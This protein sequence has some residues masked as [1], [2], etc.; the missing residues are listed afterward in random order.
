MAL[1]CKASKYKLRADLL[2]GS[3]LR[4]STGTFYV[5]SPPSLSPHNGE[6]FPLTPT[7]FFD[8]VFYDIW[9][10]QSPLLGF[11]NVR[12]ESLTNSETRTIVDITS[13]QIPE[14]N[15]VFTSY[16][17][18]TPVRGI[19]D[20]WSLRGAGKTADL[21]GTLELVAYGTDAAGYPFYVIY[22]TGPTF[23]LV[24]ASKNKN[25][26]DEG[27]FG[28]VLRAL[29]ETGPDIQDLVVSGLPI[30]SNGERDGLPETSCGFSCQNNLI[31]PVGECPPGYF[32][33]LKEEQR[34]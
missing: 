10:S 12:T 27:I 31:R 14:C 1:L 23:G 32:D 18:L 11:R 26:P 8:G 34:P 33:N 3:P 13:F 21:I 7:D 20:T 24:F 19:A 5:R 9:A 4:R 29:A 30:P 25:V 15:Y 6:Q 16:I 22:G 28:I 17:T 2:S